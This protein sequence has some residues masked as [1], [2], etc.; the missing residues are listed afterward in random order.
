M[1]LMDEKQL[2]E[3]VQADA[4]GIRLA[5]TVRP[6][7][8]V[9]LAGDYRE[10][11]SIQQHTLEDCV[12]IRTPGVSFVRPKVQPIPVIQSDDNFRLEQQE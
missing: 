7:D 4:Q 2:Q 12:L 6:G 1:F 8:Q 5:Y 10:V 9:Y 11:L 3:W